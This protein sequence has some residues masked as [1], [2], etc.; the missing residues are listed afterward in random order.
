MLSRS[1][2]AA[3]A[4]VIEHVAARTIVLH[5]SLVPPLK[6]VAEE[7]QAGNAQD[8]TTRKTTPNPP[9]GA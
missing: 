8:T 2:I 4:R 1:V 9:L 3:A 6:G 7:A 5:T